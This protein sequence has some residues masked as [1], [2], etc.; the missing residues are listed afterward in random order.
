MTSLG[1]FTGTWTWPLQAPGHS[2]SPP[3][4]AVAVLVS[5][6]LATVGVTGMAKLTWL[7]V[8][9][10][11]AM[12]QLTVWPLRVQ[13]AG[14]LPMVRLLSSVSLTTV[15]CGVAPVPTFSIVMA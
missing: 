13:P 2:G 9:S 10:P 5:R 12:V 4:V 1:A 15:A 7:R 8:A 6:M 11:A 14:R 3:P